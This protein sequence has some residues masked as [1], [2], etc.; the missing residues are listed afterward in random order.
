M[1][2]SDAVNGV[3]NYWQ[4]WTGRALSGLAGLF[5][6]AD[7]LG[8][9][10][11]PDPVVKGTIALGYPESV[12][13]GLGIVLLLSTVAYLIPRTAALG[14]ILLTGYLGGAVASH[15]RLGHPVISH[16]LFPTYVAFFLWAGLYLRDGRVRAFLRMER[17]T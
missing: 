8:K 3:A 4:V 11:K 12:I 16:V 14:L 15:V 5:L 7:A 17:A 13:G 1:K 2:G 10:M 6:L 9:L